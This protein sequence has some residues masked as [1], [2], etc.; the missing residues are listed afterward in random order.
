VK[1]KRKTTLTKGQEN[2]KNDVQIGK[3]I[4]HKFELNDEIK[5]TI[6]P[7]QKSKRKK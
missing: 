7:L 6:K 5:K 3:I 2:Q 4:Y 1:L